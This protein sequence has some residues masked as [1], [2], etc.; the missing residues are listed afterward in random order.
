MTQL[1]KRGSNTLA[2]LIIAGI[3]LFFLLIIVFLYVLNS[4]PYNTKV[5]LYQEQ[6][7][8]FSHEHHVGGLGI[9]CRYCHYSV[10]QSS[11]A[12]MPAASLCMNCHSQIWN[13][14][15]MLAP[16]RESFATG[17]PIHWQRVYDLPDFTYFN[18]SIHVAKG[19]GCETCH[20]RVDQMPLLVKATS[21]QMEWCLSCHRNPESY[22]RPLTEITTMGWV[23]PSENM[24]R[25]LVEKHGIRSQTDCYSC[26]R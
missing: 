4:S 6:P 22:L 12:G 24:G 10:E 25:E 13:N 8:P 11:F 7:I 2:R 26:H 15:Q 19:V 5:S 17:K 21:L 23:L 16:I 18:H 20:G 9:D 3:I 1:F 14:T